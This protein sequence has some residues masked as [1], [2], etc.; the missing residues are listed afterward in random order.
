MNEMK[1]ILSRRLLSN[2]Y[3]SKQFYNLK[4]EFEEDTT[5]RFP[6]IKESSP[7]ITYNLSF[8]NDNNLYLLLHEN[9]VFWKVYLQI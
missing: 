5:L 7:R 4:I 2:I 8:L 6:F 9:E 3:R 1:P